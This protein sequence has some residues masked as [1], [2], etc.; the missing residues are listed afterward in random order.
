MNRTIKNVS[1]F[2][3]KNILRK[4]VLCFANASLINCGICGFKLV[5]R[6]PR[7]TRRCQLWFLGTFAQSINVFISILGWKSNFGQRN[8]AKHPFQQKRFY[9]E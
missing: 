9:G 5:E 4:Q 2:C 3:G 6:T 8:C 1:S 7:T